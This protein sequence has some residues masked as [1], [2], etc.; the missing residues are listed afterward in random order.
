MGEAFWFDDTDPET[1]R[2]ER[3]S[4][5]SPSNHVRGFRWSGG[6]TR[7]RTRGLVSYHCEAS[8]LVNRPLDDHSE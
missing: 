4:T 7:A 1:G 3:I 6:S 5:S 2:R 8:P